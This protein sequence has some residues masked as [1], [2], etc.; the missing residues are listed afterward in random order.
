MFARREE[1]STDPATRVAAVV[2]GG[3]GGLGGG[4]RDAFGLAAQGGAGDGL[5]NR[6][7]IG[8]QRAV[9]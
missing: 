4:L 1:A 8:G 3:G 7:R 2:A 5:T 9:E 6:E